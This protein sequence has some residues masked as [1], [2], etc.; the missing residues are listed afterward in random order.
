MTIEYP[1]YGVPFCNSHKDD[2]QSSNALD[3]YIL[4]TALSVVQFQFDMQEILDAFTDYVQPKKKYQYCQ[5]E[6][7]EKTA[8][9]FGNLRRPKQGQVKGDEVRAQEARKKVWYQYK[10]KIEAQAEMAGLR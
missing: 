10:T 2:E 1:Q 8:N 6:G 3:A 5:W 4:Y 7:L 9:R